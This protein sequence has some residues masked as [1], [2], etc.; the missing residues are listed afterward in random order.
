[1]IV[2]IRSRLN[3]DR[4]C[5]SFGR[6]KGPDA[7]S[8]DLPR[9]DT[10]ADRYRLKNPAEARGSRESTPRQRTLP[11]SVHT[12][13][14]VEWSASGEHRRFASFSLTWGTRAPE[15]HARRARRYRTR[16]KRSVRNFSFGVV[17]KSLR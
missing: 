1:M 12:A 17:L 6:E 8:R 11:T 16:T 3:V 7:A 4:V 5:M 15:T 9:A 2:I 14:S 13:A 10:K